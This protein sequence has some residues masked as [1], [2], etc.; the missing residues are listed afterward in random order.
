MFIAFVTDK[1]PPFVTFDRQPAFIFGSYLH[2]AGL[3][4]IFLVDI[5]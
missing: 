3:V 2:L 1:R 4:G 5:R